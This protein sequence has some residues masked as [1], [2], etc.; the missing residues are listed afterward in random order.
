M[1]VDPSVSDASWPSS[2]NQVT[3]NRTILWI[4]EHT[5]PPPNVRQ[6]AQG[7]DLQPAQEGR[8]LVSQL[9]GSPL[10]MVWPNGAADD[11]ARLASLLAELQQ[12][13]AVS[14][15]LLPED[16][17]R[18]WQQIARRQGQFLCVGRNAPA[19]EIAARLAAAAELAPALRML[20]QELGAALDQQSGNARLIEQMDEEMRLA[21]RLQR[22][23]LPRR[24]PEVGRA[25][26]GVLY[27]PATWVSGDIYDIIR[28]DETHVGFYVADVVG[29]GMPAALL[30]MFIKKALQTKRILGSTYE[31]VSPDVAMAELNTDICD[32]N[33]SSCQFCTAV[34]AV[35][36]VSSLVLTYCRA[37]HPEPIR[38]FRDPGDPGEPRTEVSGLREPRTEVSGLR[39]PRTEVSGLGEPRTEV[40]GLREPRTEVSG[41]GRPR[42]ASG[43][44]AVHTERLEGPGSLLGIF[45]EEQFTSRSVQLRPGQRLLFYSD[46]LEEAIRPP[47]SPRETPIEQVLESYLLRPRDELL[48]RLNDQMDK[49]R[50]N[51]PL[52]DDVTAMVLDIEG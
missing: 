28:L 32:Q 2:K 38:I 39:E 30:T 15:F 18:P 19:G 24:L 10:A 1:S 13:H 17:R 31:I 25:R 8:T 9:E 49:Y 43:L 40:S 34:Y 44:P 21:A 35:L 26:F 5:L 50:G 37:G 3:E 41:L 7:W 51:N 33:L 12:A 47:D 14:I 46:G 6:A 4:G 20:H 22:D 16:D 36:D 52:V 42:A 27:L 48:L 23:F 29:H 45:P 11:P